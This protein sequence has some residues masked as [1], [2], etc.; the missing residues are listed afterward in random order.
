MDTQRAH[1]VRYWAGILFCGVGWLC[2]GHDR[3]F[4]Q[5][6]VST[7][8]ASD[9]AS[10]DSFGWS[11]SVDGTVAVV[12]APEDDDTATSSGSAYVYRFNGSAW[13]E[14]AKLTHPSFGDPNVAGDDFGTSVDISIDTIVVGAPRHDFD[15]ASERRSGAAYVFRF[16]AGS[17]Q[18]EQMLMASDHAA[19]D[20]FGG[21][22]AINGDTVVVGAAFDD[23]G[24]SA[25]GSAYV[26]VRTGSV[27]AQRAK[28][29]GNDPHTIRQFG[30]SVDIDNAGTIAIGAWQHSTLTGAA[31]VFV[32]VGFSW[33]QQGGVITSTPSMQFYNFGQSVGISG[34]TLLVGA[35]NDEA[36][37]FAGAGAAYF[38]Q[39]TTGVWTQDAQVIPSDIAAS[40]NFGWSC[41]LD[42]DNAII[43]TQGAGKAYL[44]SRIAGVWTEQ[45]TVTSADPDASGS[46]GRSVALRG[47][48]VV[49]G[50]NNGLSGGI[51]TGLAFV[52]DLNAVD[53]DG[54]GTPDCIDGC[55]AD[56]NKIAPGA[57]GCGSSEMLSGSGDA[58]DDG[59]VNGDDV[60]PFVEE[61]ISPSGPSAQSCAS[62]MDGNGIAGAEDVTL[63]VAALLAP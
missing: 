3:L 58:N 56:P 35:F 2:M 53:T 41:S 23:D 14:E 52:F 62:D 4:A 17:W 57:C 34:D 5:C 51:A 43:G 47:T 27:W 20:R 46:F 11:V 32:P 61:V 9:G 49:V 18:N 16:V 24:G 12:G 55:P 30:R 25:S 6:E 1:R 63:F 38:F 59:L 26:F 19:D 31:Y 29:I 44:Y 50:D 13:V 28:L 36:S 40:D 60:R 45:A 42:G 7:V 8:S 21:S 22:V 33:T 48:D 54:D 10:A 39:R 37:G 15:A